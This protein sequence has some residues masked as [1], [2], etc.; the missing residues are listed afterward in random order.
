MFLR[1][2]S[3]ILA[4]VAIEDAFGNKLTYGELE[5]L[6]KE[7]EMIVPKRSLVMILC[8][9]AIET[10]AFYYCQMNNHVVPMLVDKK[11]ETEL[12]FNLI[13][14]YEPKFIW[15]PDERMELLSGLKAKVI[16]RKGEHALIRLPFELHKT[17]SELALLLTTSGSTGSLK[18]VR[19]SYENL[20]CN[21][22]AFA[23][24][25][26]LNEN[27]RGITTMPMHYCF[28]LSVLHMHW[29]LGACMYITDYSMINKKFWEFFEKSKITNL[30][31]V[32]YTFEILTQINFWN[33]KND[34]VR[35]MLQGGGK[36]SENQQATLGKKLREMNKQ[37]YTGYG[38]TEATTCI[39]I[40]SY[41]KVEEKLGSI[42]QALPGIDISIKNPDNKGEG[43]LVCK[44]KSVCLGYA[45][46]KSDLANGDDNQGCLHTGDVV[47]IDEDGDIFIKGRKSR[48]VKVLGA[49][50]S[51][52]ELETILCNHFLQT[53]VACVGKDNEIRI[54]YTQSGM[55]KEILKFC[56]EMFSIP[57]K[58]IECHF[59]E[60]LPYTSNGKIKYADL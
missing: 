20:R 49:R 42:G 50:I 2:T 18:L 10:I 5:A 41:K 60:E 39:S 52:D 48:F 43:E 59:I 51:L 3:D 21:S 56:R 58:M 7:Y 45:V 11:L 38:Q 55:E 8:D 13:N 6:S 12:L 31:G 57:R 32:P 34:S 14:T 40:L 36:L 30:F 4:R 35:L 28:G 23:T 37:F 9:Y 54:Y 15:C 22:K 26:G 29:M 47:Q 17:F 33:M 24:T 19:L 44:G 53:Q 16:M 46:S 25:I 1:D 27:D